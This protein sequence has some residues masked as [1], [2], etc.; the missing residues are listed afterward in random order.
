MSFPEYLKAE[1]VKHESR[2][3][4]IPM[5]PSKLAEWSVNT[6][7]CINEEREMRKKKIYNIQKKTRSNRRLGGNPHQGNLRQGNPRQGNSRQG[8]TVQQYRL[9]SGNCIRCNKK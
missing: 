7:D 2:N 9:P 5:D 6:I 4:C 3:A 1:L 8:N